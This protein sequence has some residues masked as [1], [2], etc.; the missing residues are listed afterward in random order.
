MVTENIIRI[1]AGSVI[2]ISLAL[3]ADASP[4]F[5]SRHWLW[6]TTFVGANMFLYFSQTQAKKNDFRG[7][8]VFVVMDTTRRER[9]S[10][11]VWEED[12]RVPDVVIELHVDGGPP[13][14]LSAWKTLPALPAVQKGRLIALTGTDL[15]T[16][17]PRVG[18]A[19][20]RLARAIH[21]DAF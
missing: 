7:P 16:A 10:W 12:G 4:L 19:T 3:G 11:V 20:E 5:H 1:F 18:S 13:A 17:G 9:K 21:P 15:V 2:L 14:D 8:D 6:L